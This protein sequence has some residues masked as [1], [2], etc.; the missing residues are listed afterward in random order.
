MNSKKYTQK[1]ISYEENINH[2]DDKVASWELFVELSTRVTTQKITY[3]EGN[4]SS[5]LNSIYKLFDLTRDLLKKYGQSTLYFNE[6]ALTILN[7]VIR[8]FTSKWHKIV[9]SES[10]NATNT[11][12]LFRNDLAI[13][14]KKLIL[15]SEKLAKMADIKNFNIENILYHDNLLNTINIDSTESILHND[16]YEI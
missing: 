14:Q 9:I 1:N 2:N 4:E 8:P 15:Y 6:I 11:N 5:A 3:H 16:P 12:E 10:F 13:L 7:K